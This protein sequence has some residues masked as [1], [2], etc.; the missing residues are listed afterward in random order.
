MMGIEGCH[1]ANVSAEE[2]LDNSNLVYDV[3]YID[4]SRRK[5]GNRNT[6]IYSH[7]P[8]IT[9]MQEVLLEKGK[10]IITKL[11]PMQD[12]AEC[13]N[14]L[15]NIYKI[16][17]I[18]VGHEVKEFVVYQSKDHDTQPIIEA[19]NLGDNVISYNNAYKE[20]KKDL[21]FDNIE[22]YIYQPC[23]LYTSPSPRD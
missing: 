9:K 1:I 18:S 14:T 15:T 13:L 19:V 21:T 23:L 3:I 5:N 22:S 12:I 6:S 8:D 11:S 10:R 17:V 16:Q 20:E 2:Y 4:P 7:E